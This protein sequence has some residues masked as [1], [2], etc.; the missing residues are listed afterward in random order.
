VDTPRTEPRPQRGEPRP[1]RQERIERLTV[2][3]EWLDRGF[4]WISEN[5]LAT[6]SVLGAVI[7][8]AAILA[9][10]HELRS[11]REEAA[12]TALAA[13][14]QDLDAAFAPGAEPANPDTARQLREKALAGF[15]SVISEHEGRT[16][17]QFAVIRA[18]ELEI[19]LERFD[20][21]EKRLSAAMSQWPED[22][23]QRAVAM[24]LRGYALE[25]LGRYADAAEAYAQAAAIEAYPG[26][27]GAY[28]QAGDTFA[29]LGESER[30]VSAYEALL[31]V[32]PG[33]AER[34]G[35]LERL[36][37]L[38][39]SGTAAAAPTPPEGAS[40]PQTQ[41]AAPGAKPAP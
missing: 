30:A 41:P 12:Q 29:R 28:V 11:S 4:A 38:R 6:L 14:Q 7:A 15:E 37:G 35:V 32:D 2:L 31:L 22:S 5:A 27:A 26:R 23:V 1:P 25:R 18:A 20:A 17:A 39:S 16:G 19:D 9:G 13:V 24:R 34:A 10:T 36:E 8:L 33:F 3:D 21:A 40:A